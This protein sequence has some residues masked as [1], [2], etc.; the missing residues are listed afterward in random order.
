MATLKGEIPV[1]VTT[2]PIEHNPQPHAIAAGS[3]SRSQIRMREP[4]NRLSVAHLFVPK[5]S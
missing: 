2:A 1:A 3:L 5:I 4:Q